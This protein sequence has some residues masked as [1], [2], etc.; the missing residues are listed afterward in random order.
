VR[1]T[2]HT[3]V[4]VSG[5]WLIGGEQVLTAS[6]DRTAHIY[7]VETAKI[8]N[9]L[10]GHDQ[11]L[12][13]CMTSESQKLV[14]TASKDYTFRLW[15]FREPIQSVAV[16]QGHNGPVT[17]V[18]FS[19]LHHIIS[20]SDD[21]AVKVWDLRNMRSPITTVRLNSPVN[22]LSVCAKYH[23]IAIP[24][25]SRHIS[26]YDLNGSRVARLPRNSGKFYHTRMVNCTAWLGDHP[27]NNLISCGWD[28]VIG[29]KIQTSR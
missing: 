28:Q 24:Q 25:D 17:S 5:E 14:A 18:V 11:E 13:H 21:R 6:W 7:D 8:V 26:I 1:L 4:V 29:W 22:R 27:T 23:L 3:D 19:S 15:D 20:G 10:S 16:L 2:G 9:T 12:T